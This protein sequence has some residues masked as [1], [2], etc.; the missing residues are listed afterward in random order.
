MTSTA[1]EA[2]SNECQDLSSYF[3]IAGGFYFDPRSDSDLPTG[4]D[5]GLGN[6]ENGRLPNVLE[7]FHAEDEALTRVMAGLL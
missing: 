2:D 4:M 1:A 3:E 7:A 6:C 5:V